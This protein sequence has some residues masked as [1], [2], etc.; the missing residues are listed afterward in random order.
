MDFS[1]GVFALFINDLQFTDSKIGDFK[2]YYDSVSTDF[3]IKDNPELRYSKNVVVED[4]NF[5][6]FRE[7]ANGSD[8]EDFELDF[9]IKPYE[10][11]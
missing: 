9:E 8:R 3:V 7:V 1:S 11:S 5:L 4:S 10:M 2:F 6:I